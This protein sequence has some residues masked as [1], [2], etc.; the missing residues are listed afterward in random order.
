MKK[1]FAMSLEAVASF[2]LLVQ[3]ALLLHTFEAKTASEPDLFLCFDAVQVL[4]DSSSF[5]DE[6]VLNERLHLIS[7]LSG[8]CFQA[9]ELSTCA[10]LGGSK[11]SITF[12]VW[13]N[14]HAEAI[15]IACWRQ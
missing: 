15:T 9:E 4:I 1:A 2:I 11:T 12:P 7:N 14:S 13:R 6:A 5:S 3:A 8:I 10:Y